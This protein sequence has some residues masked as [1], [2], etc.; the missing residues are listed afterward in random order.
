MKTIYFICQDINIRYLI[1]KIELNPKVQPPQYPPDNKRQSQ[2]YVFGPHFD[3]ML[4]LTTAIRWG[5]PPT[6]PS[7]M[8][9]LPFSPS[10]TMTL[11][12]TL[13][14][15]LFFSCVCSSMNQKLTN[16]LTLV[17][18]QHF[19][20]SLDFEHLHGPLYTFLYQKR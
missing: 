10:D 19:L 6:A 14:F 2:Y 4:C 15:S 20:N 5:C 16:N 7:F 9:T 3:T 17:Q 18:G 11:G 12:F 1:Y 8:T 13:A